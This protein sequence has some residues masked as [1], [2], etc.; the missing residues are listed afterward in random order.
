LRLRALVV[1]T[2]RWPCAYLAS[3]E[4]SQLRC[5]LNHQKHLNSP[6]KANF[7]QN[8]RPSLRISKPTQ[9]KCVSVVHH[10]DKLRAFN[11][12]APS[13]RVEAGRNILLSAKIGEICGQQLPNINISFRSHNVCNI[14]PGFLK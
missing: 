7:L 12:A 14:S 1:Q 6:I 2:F 5:V 4:P 13:R 11:R 8:F 10:T 9:I 3:L